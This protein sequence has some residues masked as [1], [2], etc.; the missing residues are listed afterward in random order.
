VEEDPTVGEKL[1]AA[2]ITAAAIELAAATT[3]IDTPEKKQRQLV[4]QQQ[5]N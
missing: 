5:L 4:C 2:E 3:A 1:P